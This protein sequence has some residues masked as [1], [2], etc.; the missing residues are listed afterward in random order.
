MPP[1]APAAVDSAA[2][3]L[4]NVVR[5]ARF[6]AAGVAIGSIMLPRNISLHGGRRPTL[7]LS[8]VGLLLM[9]AT[10]FWW[11]PSGASCDTPARP[12]IYGAWTIHM[13][14]PLECGRAAAAS[15]PQNPNTGHSSPLVLFATTTA[16]KADD[17][18]ALDLRSGRRVAQR[19]SVRVSKVLNYDSWP[20][21]NST[22][23][24][25]KLWDWTKLTDSE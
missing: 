1:P 15:V 25:Y 21:G 6:D 2:V 19:S 20:F 10:G 24:D 18:S 4:T 3:Y 13:S 7:L 16:F 22:P 8:H 23:F 11:F 14:A 17:S 12:Q 9:A 5:G